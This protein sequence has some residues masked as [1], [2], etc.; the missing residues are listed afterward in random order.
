MNRRIYESEG[1][2]S[3][4]M[5]QE[6]IEKCRT[7]AEFKKLYEVKLRN[8]KHMWGKAVHPSA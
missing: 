2:G 8:R 3:T 7:I 4:E 6:Q 1:S 5:L